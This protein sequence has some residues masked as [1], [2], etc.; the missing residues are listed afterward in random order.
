M[1]KIEELLNKEIEYKK[2]IHELQIQLDSK[3]SDDKLEELKKTLKKNESDYKEKLAA[4]QK[5]NDELAFT[6]R[7]LAE[8]ILSL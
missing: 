2:T 3:N 4:V 8:K 5:E 7:Q 6:K 1:K